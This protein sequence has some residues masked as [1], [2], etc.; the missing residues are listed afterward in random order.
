MGALRACV[1][2][3]QAPT[4]VP[5]TSSAWAW[6]ASCPRSP[7]WRPRP[8]TWYHLPQSPPSLPPSIPPPCT[9]RNH[10]VRSRC[11]RSAPHLTGGSAAQP[12]HTHAALTPG[13]AC[14]PHRWAPAP[15]WVPRQ[16]SRRV[17]RRSCSGG[18]RGAGGGPRSSV[19]AT[20]SRCGCARPRTSRRPRGSQLPPP[21]RRLRRRRTK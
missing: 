11:H 14:A 7:R 5:T 1:L 8:S 20:R 16:G 3:A 6:I 21:P 4:S 18:R 17:N 2:Y 10:P 13:P 12:A 15:R 9:G 19:T